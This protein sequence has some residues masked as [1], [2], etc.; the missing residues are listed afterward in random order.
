MELTTSAL[1]ADELPRQ[2]YNL[3]ADLP[4]Q[5]P[6]PLGP[7]GQPT[8]PEDLAPVLP[9]NLIEQEMFL[10]GQLE[11]HP[12]PKEVLSRSLAALESLPRL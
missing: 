4:G 8:G 5:P 10:A 6:P 3:A 1:P 9:M 12:L 2:W 7:D 11:K